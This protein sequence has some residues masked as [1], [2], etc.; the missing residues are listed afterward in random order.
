MEQES[1]LSDT[2][3]QIFTD[4]ELENIRMFKMSTGE[5]IVAVLLSQDTKSNLA[6]V[7]RPCKLSVIQDNSGIKYLFQKWT[8]FAISDMHVIDINHIMATYK[9]N[10]E[11]VLFYIKSV[12]QQIIEEMDE[13]KEPKESEYQWP[14][15]MD[16]TGVAKN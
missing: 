11:L 7:R 3:I 9:V 13:L 1:N 2:T 12:R 4:K 16:K 15:W 8:L 5:N 14:D 10:N 6:V